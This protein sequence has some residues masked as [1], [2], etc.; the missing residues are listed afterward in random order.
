[1]RPLLV[2]V[3]RWHT[4]HVAGGNEKFEWQVVQD[5]YSADPQ[6]ARLWQ[7][8]LRRPDRRGRG[9]RHDMRRLGVIFLALAI[10]VPLA[11]A[12]LI[13]VL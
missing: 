6:R 8:N 10:A 3:S 5:R 1:V 13:A 11:I 7:R 4:R 9:Y 12:A 2:R